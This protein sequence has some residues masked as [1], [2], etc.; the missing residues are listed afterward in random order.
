MTFTDY[1]K[2]YVSN[3]ENND[4]LFAQ[5]TSATWADPLLAR[6]RK[7]IE[8]HKLGFGDPAFHYLWRILLLEAT[9]R[10]AKPRCLEIGV[11]KGQIISLWALLGR[12]LSLPL[13]L[14]AVTP[15]SGHPAPPETLWRKLRYR[16][17]RSY[18]EEV[19]NGNFYPT[20]DY[21][22]CIRR[23][24]VAFQLSWSDVRL[25]HGYSTDPKILAEMPGNEAFHLIYVDGDHTYEGATADIVN[26][27]PRV[28]KGGWIV[29]DDA[30]CDLP[31]SGFWKG[32][33]SVSQACHLLPTLGFRNILNIGHNRVFER[34]TASGSV[35]DSAPPK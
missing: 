32:H 3:A 12:E 26:F 1:T 22:K 11:F 31:G 4:R 13:E 25:W 23:L 7:H 16:F 28:A 6:H 34:I 29:M 27:A 9:V 8:E 35:A 15:L 17:S 33:P 2:Q 20:D 5:F 10:F 14:H 21:E 30:G 19:D 24:F 18:R